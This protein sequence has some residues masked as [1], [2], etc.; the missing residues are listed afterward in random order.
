MPDLSRY[1]ECTFEFQ[2]AYSTEFHIIFFNSKEE[3][4]LVFSKIIDLKNQKKIV[5]KPPT[6]E[7]AQLLLNHFIYEILI[8]K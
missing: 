7:N 8:G 6:P 1:F 3:G 5:L 2:I 4:M